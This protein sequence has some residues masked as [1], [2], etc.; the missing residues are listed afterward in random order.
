MKLPRAA[1][2]C[3]AVSL[4]GCY[5]S[6]GSQV[7][8]GSA[9][10][11]RSPPADLFAEPSLCASGQGVHLGRGKWACQGTFLPGGI[12]GLCGPGSIPCDN[13][14]GI[15]KIKCKS[16]PGF[17]AANVGG[18]SP[19]PMCSAID[20]VNFSCA[21]KPSEQRYFFRFGCGTAAAA[22][23]RGSCER[24]C[25]DFDSVM[26]CQQVSGGYSCKGFDSAGDRNEDLSTG[27][28]GTEIGSDS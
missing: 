25:G 8:P 12:A 20:P 16:L 21:D 13:A 2:L 23:F 15:D 1:L 24:T 19:F 18:Y 4:L 9:D 5:S 26:L 27:Q 6:D 14:E 28:G 10:G 3:F 22:N 7:P 11:A 17:F